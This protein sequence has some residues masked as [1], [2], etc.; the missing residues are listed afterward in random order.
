MAEEKITY[1][2]ARKRLSVPNNAQPSSYADKVRGSP[3][4]R[5]FETQTVFTWPNGSTLPILV[6]E[7]DPQ[8][9]SSTSKT[10]SSS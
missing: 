5:T 3:T 9:I 4:T 10:S 7:F 6:S 2:E 1:Q 8:K